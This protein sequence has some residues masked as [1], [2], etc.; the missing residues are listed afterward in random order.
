MSIKVT[1]L[2]S[3]VGAEISGVDLA[4]L[5]DAQFSQIEQA[6]TSHSGLLFR[7]Q[8]LTDRRTAAR[9][10]GDQHPPPSETWHHSRP[11]R[12]DAMIPGC[13]GCSAMDSGPV[14]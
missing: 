1:P 6:W 3:A 4:A 8:H 14:W 2:T 13:E 7:D 5:S 9:S 12:N 10:T 11:P